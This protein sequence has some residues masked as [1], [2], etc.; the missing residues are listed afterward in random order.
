MTI[1]TLFLENLLR[2]FLAMLVAGL[3][4][5]VSL[6]QMLKLL[7]ER[8]GSRIKRD[9]ERMYGGATPQGCHFRIAVCWARWSTDSNKSGW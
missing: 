8:S 3:P 6:E 9:Q 2:A 1:R 5:R 4:Q 7:F